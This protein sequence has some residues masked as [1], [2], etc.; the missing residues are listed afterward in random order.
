M[1]KG[2]L[3]GAVVKNLSANAGGLKDVGSIPGLGV[4]PKVG[5]GH[6]LQYSCQKIPWTE[7]PGRLQSMGLGKVRH[8]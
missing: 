5:N 4:S 2:F 3:G 7:G 6:L 8:D 1:S